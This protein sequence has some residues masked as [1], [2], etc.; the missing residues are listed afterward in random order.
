[1]S[2]AGLWIA[3][4]RLPKAPESGLLGFNTDRVSGKVRKRC[5]AAAEE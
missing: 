4:F 5:F 1:M 3:G 2:F